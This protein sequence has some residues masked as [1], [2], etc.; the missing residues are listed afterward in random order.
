MGAV[1]QLS[2]RVKSEPRIEA[3]AYVHEDQQMYRAILEL[4]RRGDVVGVHRVAK[5]GLQMTEVALQEIDRLTLMV[6][7]LEG[8]GGDVA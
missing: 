1:I 7:D 6:G 8:R 3:M 5:H 2:D 4:N